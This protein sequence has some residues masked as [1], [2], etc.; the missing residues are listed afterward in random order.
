MCDERISRILDE[1]S[2][3]D[4]G[5][6]QEIAA[7]AP[8]FSI[9]NNIYRSPSVLRTVNTDILCLFSS[10]SPVP[11]QHELSSFLI[12]L[13]VLRRPV[14]PAVKSVCCKMETQQQ[15]CPMNED[16]NKLYKFKSS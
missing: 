9:A 12:K 4:Q 10:F 13:T 3:N 11:A 15:Q 6:D 1:E 7:L 8:C 14:N 5:N 2:T 16:S